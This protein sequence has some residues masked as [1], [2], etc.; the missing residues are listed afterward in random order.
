MHAVKVDAGKRLRL[1]ALRPGDYY[2]PEVL[3]PDLINLRRVP[4]PRRAKLTKAQ[5]LQA[6]SGAGCVHPQLGPAQGRNPGMML[7]DTSVLIDGA[8][9]GISP[10]TESAK[11]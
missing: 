1:R 10:C 6:L 9:P 4:A 8:R 7:F 2:E 11:G 5:A 3:S